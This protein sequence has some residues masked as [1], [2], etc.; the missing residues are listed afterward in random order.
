MS[1][2]IERLL[3][4]HRM[5]SREAR[6]ESRKKHPN[7]ARIARLRAERLAIKERV[8]RHAPKQPRAIT[9]FR[10]VFLRLLSPGKHDPRISGREHS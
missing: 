6:R 2:L 3:A 1:G 10:A 7:A 8:G 9:F 4:A 5:L